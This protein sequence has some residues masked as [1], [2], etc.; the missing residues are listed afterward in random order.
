MR[1]DSFNMVK[2]KDVYF[3]SNGSWKRSLLIFLFLYISLFSFGQ[4]ECTMHD[5][6]C[7][8]FINEIGNFRGDAENGGTEYLE[9]L[10]LPNR[11]NPHELIDLSYLI[12]DDN[13]A[14]MKDMGSEQGHIAF[15]S[16]FPLVAPGSLIL[17]YNDRNPHS[18]I[19]RLKDGLPN[20]DGVYQIPFTSPMIRR[21]SHPNHSDDSYQYGTQYSVKGQYW[22]DFIPFR[23][24]G[25]AVQIRNRDLKVIHSLYW[26]NNEWYNNH[27]IIFRKP[28]ANI[29]IQ[30]E[31]IS[32]FHNFSF[33]FKSG[34]WTNE[35]NYQVSNA[36][37]P[38][39]P[40]SEDN[41]LFIQNA[42]NGLSESRL[43][44]VKIDLEKGNDGEG[45]LPVIHIDGGL[46]PVNLELTNEL[47]EVYFQQ[48]VSQFGDIPLR[49][50]EFSEGRYTLIVRY[51]SQSEDDIISVNCNK[52]FDIYIP[53][54]EVI[55]HEQCDLCAEVLSSLESDC[56]VIVD[57]DDNVVEH[58]NGVY[59]LCFEDENDVY[60]E[61]AKNN[62]GEIVD[63]I[64]HRIDLIE[65][66][67]SIE[68][69]YPIQC[70]GAITVSVIGEF[71]S[72][73]W[74]NGEESSFI[75]V[76]NEGA[77]N[78]TITYMDCEYE[79]I[80]S[81][82]ESFFN[83]LDGDGVCD[84]EDCD[85]ENQLV[86]AIGMPCN[87][88]NAGTIN[89][90][91]NE[92]CECVGEV[93]QDDPCLGEDID[94]DGVCDDED[95]DSLNSCDPN[96]QDTDGDG[97]CDVVDCHPDNYDLR[98]IIGDPCDDGNASTILDM[99]NSDC[100]CE[101]IPNP[102][103]SCDGMDIDGDGI[104]DNEDPDPEDECNGLDLKITGSVAM[105]GEEAGTTL[106]AI[107]TDGVAP[108]FY[109]WSTGSE[110]SAID[111]SLSDGKY[112]YVT[113]T[114]NLG[115][116][117]ISGISIYNI[118][119]FNINIDPP[120]PAFCDAEVGV[121]VECL[122]DYDTYLWESSGAQSLNSK[123]VVLNQAGTWTLTVVKLVDGTSCTDVYSFEVRDLSNTL[124]IEAYFEDAGF[125]EVPITFNNLPGVE[126]E[127]G[128]ESSKSQHCNTIDDY[129]YSG[130]D[131]DNFGFINADALANGI[132]EVF[133]DFKVLQGYE[134]D[135]KV[136]IVT[137]NTCLCEI[138]IANLEELYNKGE[139]SLWMHQFKAFSDDTRGKMFMKA[140]TKFD[141]VSP[142]DEMHKSYLEG[143]KH[144]S[145][146]ELGTNP[147]T[148][149]HLAVTL[150]NMFMTKPFTDFE[151]LATCDEEIDQD[152]YLVT[153]SG[154]FVNYD[155]DWSSIVFSNDH[156][157]MP[158][159]ALIAYRRDGSDYWS[160]EYGPFLHAGY[161]DASK[162]VFDE[163]MIAID[164]NE[165]EVKIAEPCLNGGL[166]SISYDLADLTGDGGLIDSDGGFG[167]E[168]AAFNLFRKK[169]SHD[170]VREW[171]QES[172]CK[173]KSMAVTGIHE[174]IYVPERFLG[175][176]LFA[177]DVVLV[178]K[179]YDYVGVMIPD[180]DLSEDE[181][182]ITSVNVGL[183]FLD[184][185]EDLFD[186]AVVFDQSGR[187][188]I[189]AFLNQPSCKVKASYRI[190]SGQNGFSDLV[191][192]NF[193]SDGP[194]GSNVD[195]FNYLNNHHNDKQNVLLFV[196]GYRQNTPN[197]F[198][199]Y[200]RVDY[201]PYEEQA[202]IDQYYSL[203][204]GGVFKEG[205][206]YWGETGR[207]F[208]DRIGTH[209]V[210]Y[211]DGHDEILTA[212]HKS[213]LSPQIFNSKLKFGFSMFSSYR[214]AGYKAPMIFQR[215]FRAVKF[216]VDPIPLVSS[217]YHNNECVKLNEE[218]NDD[219]F[220]Q[221]FANG[222]ADAERFIEDIKQGYVDISF[223]DQDEI[224]ANIDIV[225]HSMGFAHAMGMISVLKQY[226][227]PDSEGR[228]RLGRFYILAPENSCSI[229]D[230]M[231][232]DDYEE[233]WQYG[234]N[235]NNENRWELDGVAAQCEDI[236]NMPD[237]KR[238]FLEDYRDTEKYRDFVNAHL[239][240]NYGWLFTAI[241]PGKGYIETR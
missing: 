37:T 28:S 78:V 70:S 22:K 95:P 183:D 93:L 210:Y 143:E 156:D 56:V 154:D 187:L 128:S 209:N 141:P 240:S 29:G 42:Q 173:I 109:E 149:I 112:Y 101:G 224:T 138:G 208:I 146:I 94:G 4:Q 155:N 158:D 54:T 86:G 142:V 73:L 62:D 24:F 228:R 64:E 134:E 193:P 120:V 98:Y 43:F 81:I 113:V 84:G 137:G 65:G 201:V 136:D 196:N 116:V 132:T 58:D 108:F 87:D 91:I 97:V 80:V 239:G 133:N 10:V 161:Y 223:T 148:E 214:A 31:N 49:G 212:N 115:C 147:S 235:P 188:R 217:C 72:V 122:Q 46:L 15:S 151:Y 238:I 76:E 82:D 194:N 107:V 60:Y 181:P 182:Y 96:G 185:D 7:N 83:D 23:D 152:A 53:E 230:G 68:F 169:I 34:D 33:G 129:R 186:D 168:V 229:G 160:Y 171:L 166:C 131:E 104:C 199:D 110:Q 221:R 79:D 211:F 213:N 39:L 11:N 178:N 234:S 92:S 204:C 170:D 12:V 59:N 40:N 13:N 48:V 117:E 125:Y 19:D 225:A 197:L 202:N 237:R 103:N 25:D 3:S 57:K 207:Q 5:L 14:P 159:G 30:I 111:V 127:E 172:F 21:Y 71:E 17:L 9:L 195:I 231:N 61:L 44:N 198:S 105:C 130:D 106:S 89:D 121:R 226:K 123:S 50:I 75:I 218:P 51:E 227:A 90:V 150:R 36:G 192:A 215:M 167:N 38:G 85:I 216:L 26:S 190:T 184:D 35:A 69:E 41:A 88:G 139:L 233:V 45:F 140:K 163:D 189:C 47:G 27:D 102:N 16:L 180:V 55:T 135:E 203:S 174:E 145:I 99:I 18:S 222:V 200:D 1:R 162:G 124:D 66:D 220:Q 191:P 236:D 232:I 77:Y 6:G 144:S 179:R 241:K 52:K 126:S 165:Q 119:P 153:P 63:I 164:Q 157:L 2:V 74:S 205:G 32:D 177:R 100:Q 206:D 67:Y 114:D 219:G 8:V 118:K 175:H 176:Y 20:Q